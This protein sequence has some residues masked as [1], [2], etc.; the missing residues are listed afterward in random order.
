MDHS[1]NSCLATDNSRLLDL[2]HY[3]MTTSFTCKYEIANVKYIKYI[4]W[5][6]YFISSLI[7]KNYCSAKLIW[8]FISFL[9]QWT[10]LSR[11]SNVSGELSVHVLFFLMF[12]RK[13]QN[14]NWL[15]ERKVSLWYWKIF[16]VHCD[17]FCNIDAFICVVSKSEWNM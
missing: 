13:Q 7:K 15:Y 3:N 12:V 10:T 1:E 4:S 6:L 9:K 16:C 14:A 5:I 17:S 2:L 11:A 8:L